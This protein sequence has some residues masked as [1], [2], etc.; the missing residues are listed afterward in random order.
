MKQRR[1]RPH[2]EECRP[3]TQAELLADAARTELANAKSLAQLM[4]REEAIKKK[5]AVKKHKYAGP[6]M[7][8]HSKVVDG[9]TQVG[10]AQALGSARAHRTRRGSRQAR[11]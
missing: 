5:G 3:L 8:Y 10:L 4:A 6:L 7:R 2:A 1:R 9:V 11:S